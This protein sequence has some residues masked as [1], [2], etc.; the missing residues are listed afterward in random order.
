MKKKM[1]KGELCPEALASS[2]THHSHSYFINRH[3][4]ASGDADVTK[5]GGEKQSCL[6]PG[7]LSRQPCR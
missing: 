5:C 1:Q 4:K 3:H 2:G 7:P 6:V